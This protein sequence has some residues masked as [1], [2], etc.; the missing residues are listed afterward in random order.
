[1]NRRERGSAVI[2]VV[3]VVLV[4]TMVGLAAV[5]FMNLEQNLTLADR[6]SKET[7]YI[8]E[9]GMRQG[10]TVVRSGSVNINSLLTY[11]STYSIIP[12][13]IDECNDAE[14]L[15]A[16]LM[17]TASGILYHRVTPAFYTPPSGYYAVYSLYVR[18]NGDDP[19]R[20]PTLDQD[21]RLKIVCVG[22]VFVGDP[23][24]DPNARLVGRK[25]IEE[26]L[27]SGLIMS[28]SDQIGGSAAGTGST[29]M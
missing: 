9:T 17:D 11:A 21:N 26:M 15:G 19:S 2:T 28:A 7:L 18:N 8:A 22:E 29:H 6:L 23:T 3:L 16:V 13:T 10:E 27:G 24:A 5:I 20:D 14:H 25:V 1:M 4:L 12:G